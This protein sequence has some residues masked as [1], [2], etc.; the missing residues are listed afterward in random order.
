M[1]ADNFYVQLRFPGQASCFHY[2]GHFDGTVHMIMHRTCEQRKEQWWLFEL[3]TLSFKHA[4]DASICLN[5]NPEKNGFDVWK[6]YSSPK[7]QFQFD[8]FRLTYCL[9]EDLHQCL[10]AT[11]THAG[12]RFTTYLAQLHAVLFHSNQVRDSLIV[13]VL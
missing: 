1:F 6:C 2:G 12:M 13:H 8:E 9:R 7:Q 4:T 3:E 5:W 11:E 10:Q